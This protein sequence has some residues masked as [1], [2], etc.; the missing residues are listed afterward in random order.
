MH[1]SVQVRAGALMQ[2]V[3]TATIFQNWFL[4]RIMRSSFGAI[5]ATSRR[6]T[7]LARVTARVAL[8][9]I[10]HQ[11]GTGVPFPG[12]KFLNWG[13]VCHKKTCFFEK[14]VSSTK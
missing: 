13:V 5:S 7:S 4:L 1:M 2:F 3:A 14:P 9:R 6:G 10:V 8:I 12:S 11:A